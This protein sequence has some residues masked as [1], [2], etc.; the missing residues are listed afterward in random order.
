MNNKQLSVIVIAILIAACIVGFSIYMGLLNSNEIEVI[1]NMT[2]S[3]NS[4]NETIDEMVDDIEYEESQSSEAQNYKSEQSDV[5]EGA[6]YSAQH[7][8]TIYTGEIDYAPDEHY[9][10]HLGNNEWERID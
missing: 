7:G 8:R 10:R 3:T 6:F 4:T 1:E 5:D 9:W 2:N